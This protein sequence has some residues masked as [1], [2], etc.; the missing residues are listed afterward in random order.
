MKKIN[1]AII[2]ILN[3]YDFKSVDIHIENDSA[4][5][6]GNTKINDEDVNIHIKINK[7]DEEE[8]KD[9]MKEEE[10]TDVDSSSKINTNHNLN[11]DK[12]EKHV[13]DIIL[14]AVQGYSI[15]DLMNKY[16]YKET[17]IRSYISRSKDIIVSNFCITPD[18]YNKLSVLAR[19]Q[20]VDDLRRLGFNRASIVYITNDTRANITSY[21]ILRNCDPV[22]LVNII[23]DIINDDS[24]VDEIAEKYNVNKYIGK[25]ARI[26]ANK[27]KHKTY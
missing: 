21:S 20:Y 25:Y 10:S 23:N 26:V 4:D 6:Y 14:N 16:N 27:I 11:Y 3:K 22:I 1:G 18:I 13:G 9:V 19:I 2:S 15:K 24:N 17:T 8:K 7:I 5:L 12:K